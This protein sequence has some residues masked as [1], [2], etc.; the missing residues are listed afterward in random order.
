VV[1]GELRPT[2]LAGLRVA[3]AKL[4]ISASDTVLVLSPVSVEQ[5]SSN[6][7][8]ETT[9]RTATAGPTRDGVAQTADYNAAVSMV[10]SRLLALGFQPVSQAM[11]AAA[12][13]RKGKDLAAKSLMQQ[14]LIVGAD[15]KATHAL[16]LR[17]IRIGYADRPERNLTLDHPDCRGSVIWLALKVE[18]DAVLV[19]VDDGRV[20]WTGKIDLLFSD[21]LKK[22]LG[23][24][25]EPGCQMKMA[26]GGYGTFFCAERGNA[27]CTPEDA[28]RQDYEA[29]MV[30]AF[31][32]LLPSP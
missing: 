12:A 28:R 11:I 16:L 13:D 30:K 25:L 20:A 21:L 1:N 27:R 10:E 14:A 6:L 2:T 4:P 31:E 19:R 15:A 26:R 22:P 7:T 23:L 18:I 32:L 29:M 17:S 3:P 8:A 24:S 9:E 5:V